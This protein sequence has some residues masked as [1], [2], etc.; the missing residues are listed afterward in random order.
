[1][2][3]SAVSWLRMA[4]L[5]RPERGGAG[6]FEPRCGPSSAGGH[7]GCGGSSCGPATRHVA[8]CQCGPHVEPPVGS[9]NI[10]GTVPPRAA[11]DAPAVCWPA[12]P[13]LRRCSWQ[14]GNSVEAPSHGLRLIRML[15]VVAVS[16]NLQKLACSG[17]SVTN[18]ARS[19]LCWDTKRCPHSIC[20][21]SA[22]DVLRDCT[23]E[24]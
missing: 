16:S 6:V 1:M 21:W 15:P 5:M 11:L 17:N 18:S 4:G 7:A 9:R 20:S 23:N 3:R 2:I 14:P 24:A 19:L 13:G 10:Y 8:A 12:G 22:F